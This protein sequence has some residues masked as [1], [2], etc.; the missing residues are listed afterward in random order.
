MFPFQLAMVKLCRTPWLNLPTH[1]VSHSKVRF[2][3]QN[4]GYEKYEKNIMAELNK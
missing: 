3:K 1:W 2:G 4:C